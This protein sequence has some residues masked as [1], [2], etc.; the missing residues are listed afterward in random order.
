MEFNFA[1][2]HPS[3][4][5]H[6]PIRISRPNE[7]IAL[8]LR[9][10]L[11][12]IRGE[13]RPTLTLALPVVAAEL[14]WM[15]MGVVDTLIVSR[16]GSEAI[17][18]VGLGSMVFFAVA[19][20][21][22]GILLGL[23]TVVAQAFGAGDLDGCHRALIQGVFLALALTPPLMAIAMS[24]TPLLQAM[25][26][27]PSVIRETGP[28]IQ[29]TS[30][31]TLP[32]LIYAAY[33]RYL[34]AMGI[35]RPVMFALVSANIV[36]ALGNWAFVY[37]KL[38]A[39]AMGVEGS[40]WA[41]SVSRLYLALVLMGYTYWRAYR[42]QTGLL[43]TKWRPDWRLLKRLVLL[44]FPAALHVTLEVGVFAAATA[45]TA[46][47]DASSLAAHQIVLNVSS[48]T[49]MIPFGLASA[50]A[51][52]VG[53]AIGRNDPEAAAR[54]GWTTL[55]LGSLFMLAAGLTLCV[56][57]RTILGAFSDD[58]RVTAVGVSLLF[59]VAGFQLFDGLQAVTTGNLRGAGDTH[60]PMACNL[61]AHWG[62]GLPI[63]YALCFPF[64][65]GVF[66]L[67]LGLSVGLIAAGSVLLRVWFLKTEALNKR[68]TF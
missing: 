15:G 20:F 22:I 3:F 53:H 6:D 35:V 1:I 47:L 49:F 29:V 56:F 16:L 54:A 30:L 52:R 34:Q 2:R 48:V 58:P 32:L 24:S 63:G 25:G 31:S 65:M 28:Y 33:R 45:L 44:G 59:V 17:G 43:E 4:A 21:G 26:V 61:V 13:L 9:K 57:P 5:T 42:E 66:G 8:R 19:V 11:R 39:P 64:R 68:G 37:G 60:T 36:N 55:A 18:A 14:G 40:A 62:I 27:N 51:V 12:E 38:G 23:D 10:G 67:W 50:G 46:R 7:G 41:T